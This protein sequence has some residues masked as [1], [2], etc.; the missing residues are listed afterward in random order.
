MTQRRTTDTRP[1]IGQLISL[2]DAAALAR[3]DIKTIRRWIDNGHL[4]AYRMGSRLVRVER[5]ELLT[6]AKPIPAKRAGG[7]TRTASPATPDGAA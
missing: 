1:Q 3:V 2:R 4:H 7:S 5:N 6:I